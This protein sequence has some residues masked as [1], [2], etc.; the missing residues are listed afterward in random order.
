MQA[1]GECSSLRSVRV[2]LV[3]EHA[4]TGTETAC[5]QEGEL[6]VYVA[7]H[8]QWCEHAHP[9]A[10]ARLPGDAGYL[11]RYMGHQRAPLFGRGPRCA[12]AQQRFVGVIE[13][14]A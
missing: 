11:P 12:H 5:C 6:V 8:R 7:A 4:V 2:V 14:P 10:H 1:S 13:M 3:M 9:A